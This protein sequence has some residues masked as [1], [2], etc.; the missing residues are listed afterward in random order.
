[1]P[2]RSSTGV[3]LD[4]ALERLGLNMRERCDM[5]TYWLPQLQSSPFNAIYFVQT[6]LYEKAARLTIVPAPDVTIRVFMAFR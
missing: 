2:P 4:R 1:M 3:F 6:A 5:I